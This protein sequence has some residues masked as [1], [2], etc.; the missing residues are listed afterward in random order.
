ME[1][2]KDTYKDTLKNSLLDFTYVI[3]SVFVIG[4]TYLTVNKFNPEVSKVT[5]PTSQVLGATTRSESSI[6][7]FSGKDNKLSIISNYTLSTPT[8]SNGAATVTMSLKR[9]EATQYSINAITVKNQSADLKKIRITPSYT[10]NGQYVN[11]SITFDGVTKTVIDTNG[12]V[13]PL[14]LFISPN[15][16]SD[17]T[18]S[19]QANTDI[20]SPTQLTLS[21]AEVQ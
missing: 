1:T 6:Q 14:D 11:I 16:A 21:I 12:T 7:Y 17:I 10:L 9:L 20:V 18:V 2:K 13:T 8:Q 5:T 4:A 19:L 15:S 3:A